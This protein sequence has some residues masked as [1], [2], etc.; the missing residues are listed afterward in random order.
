ME[1]PDLHIG[2]G[3]LMPRVNFTR[4]FDFRPTS[5]VVLAN[6]AGQEDVLIT[7]AHAKAAVEA[8]AATYVKGSEPGEAGATSGSNSGGSTESNP[9]SPS[10]KR[11]GGDGDA[12]APRASNDRRSGK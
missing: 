11:R 7:T 6:K 2:G 8:G 5:G 1:R 9:R 12:K 10:A 4:D 3:N